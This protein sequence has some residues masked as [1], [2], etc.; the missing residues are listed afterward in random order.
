VF[1]AIVD[2]VVS[3]L[4]VD[5]DGS[6]VVELSNDDDDDDDDDDDVVFQLVVV[7]VV[8]VLARSYSVVDSVDDPRI[9]WVV[10]KS[11]SAGV[12]L[13]CGIGSVSIDAG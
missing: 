7:D 13:I 8:E 12:L 11:T 4:Y 1:S 2:A 9:V 3:F 5:V 6:V 10:A